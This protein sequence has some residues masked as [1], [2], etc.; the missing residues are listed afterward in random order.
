MGM[1]TAYRLLVGR[2]EGKRLLEKPRHKW[3]DNVKMI[4]ERW[5]GVVWTGLGLSGVF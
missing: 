5:H 4:L 1:R 2:P 3:V